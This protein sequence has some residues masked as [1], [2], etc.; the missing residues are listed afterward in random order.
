MLIIDA[1][2]RADARS[3]RGGDRPAPEPGTAMDLMML[4]RMRREG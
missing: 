3:K 4:Q 2:R 1:E